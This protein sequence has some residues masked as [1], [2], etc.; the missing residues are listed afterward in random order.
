M[1]AKRELEAEK[2]KA[3]EVSR[4]A[5]TYSAPR[6]RTLDA[7]PMAVD[8]V[9]FKCALSGDTLLPKK[10]MEAFIDNFLM[11]QLS[12][13][14]MMTSALMIH[15]LNKDPDRSKI[16]METLSKY[17]DNIVEHPSEEK[18]RKIRV[19]NKAFQDR[20]AKM[21]GTHEFLQAA[22]FQSQKMPG[23]NG[24][25][26]EFLVMDSDH[27][28]NTEHLTTLKDI[29]LCAEPIKPELDHD[30]KVFYPSQN[31]QR[32]ELP[33]DFFT[34]SAEELRKEQQMKQEASEKL[35]MLRTKEMRERERVRELRR[36]R[37]CLIRVRFPDGVLLQGT[38][39]AHD[40]FSVVMDFIRECLDVDW[41]PFTVNSSTG[42]KLS[43]ETQ[44]LAELGLAPA[45]VIN[46]QYDPT[47][48]KEVAAQRGSTQF[49]RYL[50]TELLA[51][52][53]SL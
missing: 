38:F 34:M 49:Q 33:P 11:E 15:T 39:R 41:I 19:N 45:S 17:I 47:V 31:A 14:P 9:F 43:E 37:F 24:T 22:G 48:L 2:K 21:K 36:Y 8:G 7:P 30:I 35:G 50:K 10:E 6:E 52:I 29:L 20:V 16:C 53:Q 5:E 32:M 46:F 42:H 1:Q 26:E 51:A 25:D 23:P 28:Q 44:S 3:S 27:A 12:E 4:L 40:K 13:E 18:F